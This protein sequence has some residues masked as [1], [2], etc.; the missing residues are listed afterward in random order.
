MNEYTEKRLGQI[1]DLLPYYWDDSQDSNVYKF[2]SVLASAMGQWEK[3]MEEIRDSRP[4]DTASGVSLDYASNDVGVVRDVISFI[5]KKT[6]VDVEAENDQMLRS[7]AKWNIDLQESSGITEQLKEL[8][9]EGLKMYRVR[10]GLGGFVLEDQVEVVSFLGE[11]APEWSIPES[12]NLSNQEYIDSSDVFVFSN[13]RPR[14][15]MEAPDAYH[16]KFGNLTNFYTVSIPWKA[17]PWAEGERSLIWRSQDEFDSPLFARFVESD[18]DSGVLSLDHELDTNYPVVS[19]INDDQQYIDIN[20]ISTVDGTVDLDLSGYDVDDEWSVR[21]LGDGYQRWFDDSHLD[22]EVLTVKHSLSSLYPSVTIF[23]DEDNKIVPDGIEYIDEDTLRVDLS[24]QYVTNTID[25]GTASTTSF[26]ALE[27]DSIDGGDATTDST[28]GD[29][30]GEWMVFVAGGDEVI[31]Y[32]K[33]FE[34]SDLTAR[35]IKFHHNL[36]YNNPDVIIVD[37]NNNLYND[38][39]IAQINYNT[40]RVRF[41]SKETV[42]GTWKINI[43]VSK[44]NIPRDDK[45]GWNNSVWSGQEEELHIEPVQKIVDL[46]RPAATNVGINGHGGMIWKSQ[47]EFKDPSDPPEDK[48]HGWGARW[49]G[50]IEETKWAMENLDDFWIGY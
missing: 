13:R 33:E 4:L 3:E 45:N 23:D 8:I 20:D 14:L 15:G 6:D 43:L 22:N 9:A 29:T 41:P 38:A 28:D 32:T 31:E 10:T 11:G 26:D 21:L 47:E 17:L 39:E 46:T 35:G 18:L 37:D 7:R 48:N 44:S 50:D 2:W 19:V 12:I 1:I 30:S 49:D 24:N 34:Q 25:G 27:E 36:T 40:T 5:S 16:G 42:T